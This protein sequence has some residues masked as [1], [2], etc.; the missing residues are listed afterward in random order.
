[1]RLAPILVIDENESDRRKL[2]QAIENAGFAVKG[3]QSGTQALNRLTG[4]YPAFFMITHK[5]FWVRM[6]PYLLWGFHTETSCSS[7]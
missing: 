1:M 4:G 6:I 3:L 7:N 2:V 5:P